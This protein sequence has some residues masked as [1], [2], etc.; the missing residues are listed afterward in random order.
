MAG[1]I[2]RATKTVLVVDWPS[3]EVPETLARA[4]YDVVVRGGPGPEDHSTYVVG[5]DDEVVV[6]RADSPPQ[7]V[8]LVYCYRPLA[9]LPA[10]VERAQRLGARAVWAQVPTEDAEAARDLVEAAGL[11]FVDRPYLPDAVRA[12]REPPPTP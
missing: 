12:L 3:R 8:D 5:D 1:D 6:R 4:G 11:A 2:L 10:I 9:E 7:R